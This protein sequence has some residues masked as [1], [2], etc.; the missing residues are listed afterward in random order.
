MPPPFKVELA[1]HDPHWL[2]AALAE[3]SVLHDA[4]GSA[5]LFV[6]HVGSTAIPGLRA[7]P[8]LD[9][10][11]VVRSLCEM[12]LRK[13]NLEQIGYDWWGEFGLPGRRYATKNEPSTGRRLVQ[14]HCYAIGAP[15]IDRHLAF[16]DHLRKRPEVVA[17]YEIEKARCRAL[18]PDD[19][20]AYGACKSAWI[21]AVETAALTDWRGSSV[22]RDYLSR[23]TG[24]KPP[25]TDVALPG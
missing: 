14:L 2:A 23:P 21:E 7:K 5:L 4:L 1:N 12:D 24:R 6:H 11:P 9:L 25:R 3:A 15:D 19:S 8:I 17:A 20:H 16:R 22:G 18:Y 10:L 13:T